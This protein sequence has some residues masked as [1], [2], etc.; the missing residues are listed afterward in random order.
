[1]NLDYYWSQAHSWFLVLS[2]PST[3]GHQH[4]DSQGAPAS[5]CRRRCSHVPTRWSNSRV[6]AALHMSPIG[7]KWTCR[8]RLS[9]SAFGGIVLQKSPS[10][11]CG[12]Q[13]W[14]N[15]IEASAFLN[16]RYVLLNQCFALGCSKYFCNTI[17][18]K[19]DIPSG[20]SE[21][22]RTTARLGQL[23]RKICIRRHSA[24]R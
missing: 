13:I 17:G 6:F 22:S 10:R 15:R 24:D 23:N 21:C 20:Y 16:Q 5:P 9:M 1:M 19:T 18:G 4:E 3:S 14:N 11:C 12:I 2:Q 7:T 8:V